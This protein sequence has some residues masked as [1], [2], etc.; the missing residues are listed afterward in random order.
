[1]VDKINQR[2]KKENTLKRTE[3][4]ACTDKN[5]N[6][7]EKCNSLSVIIIMKTSKAPC[8][9]K[10]CTNITYITHTVMETVINFKNS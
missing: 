6:L 5:K 3:N 10:C 9:S 7:S 1:M 8:G 2:V 4:E